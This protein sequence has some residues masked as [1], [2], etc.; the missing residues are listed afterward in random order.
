MN[1]SLASVGNGH[2]VGTRGCAG[3]VVAVA[4]ARDEFA[5]AA[6]WDHVDMHRAEAGVAGD[7]RWIVA[8]GVLVTNVMGDLFA[9]GVHVFHVFR[10][11][12]EPARGL[13]NGEQSLLGGFS[14]FLVFGA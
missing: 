13:R 4:G 1:G 8:K 7:I 14:A 2:C 9:D 11:K 6:R 12:S 5:A 10:E 3:S